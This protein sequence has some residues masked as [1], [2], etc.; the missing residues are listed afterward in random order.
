MVQSPAL[1]AGKLPEGL[2]ILFPGDTSHLL[3]MGNWSQIP[4]QYFSL[5]DLPE[6]VFGHYSQKG[7]GSKFVVLN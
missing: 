5:V 4:L 2:I 7:N 3:L 6:L 1:L